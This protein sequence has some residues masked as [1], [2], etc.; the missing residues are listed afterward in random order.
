[1]LFNQTVP[2]TSAS[3]SA[4][5]SA[6]H[7]V[8]LDDLFALDRAGRQLFPVSVLPGGSFRQG[9]QPLQSRTAWWAFLQPLDYWTGN[10][11]L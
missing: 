5:G 7:D 11:P 8:D 2:E 10:R 1:M 4:A 9:L 3:L 6:S